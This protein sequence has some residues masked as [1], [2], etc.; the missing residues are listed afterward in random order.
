MVMQ[1]G[2]PNLHISNILTG[3]NKVYTMDVPPCIVADRTLVPVRAISESLGMDVQWD[4]VT[5]TVLITG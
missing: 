5:R 3:E 2:Q 1:I 4:E